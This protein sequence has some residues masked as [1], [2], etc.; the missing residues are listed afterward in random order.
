M[1]LSLLPFL[2][3]WSPIDKKEEGITINNGDEYT[4]ALDNKGGVIFAKFTVT[5]ADA[6]IRT[7]GFIVN[8]D[9]TVTELNN[10]RQT[11]PNMVYLSQT[12]SPYVVIFEPREPMGY[13][14]NG[15]IVVSLPS[16]S[17]DTSMT[18]D[19]EVRGFEVYDQEAFLNGLRGF[20]GASITVA[21]KEIREI[22]EFYREEEV[23]VALVQLL[24]DIKE[25]NAQLITWLKELLEPRTIVR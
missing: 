24:Q 12:Q 4:I 2:D 21:P 25:T 11:L 9:V 6:R 1:L 3:G 13:G 7:E 15:K 8:F 18:L 19:Y 22:K 5:S 20:M 10:A 14:E 17:S 16:S 23:P